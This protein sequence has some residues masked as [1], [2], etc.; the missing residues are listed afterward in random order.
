MNIAERL[1]GKKKREVESSRTESRES[2]QP[3][4]RN[5]AGPPAADE[6][7][8][9]S[10]RSIEEKRPA[11]IGKENWHLTVSKDRLTAFLDYVP[12]SDHPSP[13]AAELIRAAMELGVPEEGIFSEEKLET[14]LRNAETSGIPLRGYAICEDLEGGF[15]INVSEDKLR[16]TLSL[17]K[18]RGRGASLDLKEVGKALRS[19]NIKRLD[20]DKLKADILEFYRGPELTLEEYELATGKAPQSGGDQ[21]LTWEIEFM[22]ATDL[23]ELK[24]SFAEA[25]AEAFEGIASLEEC[26]IEAVQDATFI[27]GEM[28][29]ATLSDP[30]SAEN[31]IDVYGETIP[32]SKGSK[33]P[34]ELHENCVK[35]DTKIA[36]EADGIL[37][38]WV[39]DDTPHIRVRPHADPKITVYISENAMSAS[40]DLVEGVGTGKRLHPEEV[41]QALIDAGVVRGIDLEAVEEAITTAN[42]EG[43]A[44]Q[45]VVARGEQ[46]QANDEESLKFH[47]ELASGKGVTI[48]E[49]GRADFKNQ[50]RFTKVDE[51]TL[52]AEVVTTGTTLRPG[53]DVKGNTIEAKEAREFSLDIGENIK[54]ERDE[55]GQLRLIAGVSGE[56]AY[57]GKSIDIVGVHL[58]KGDVGP[59]TGNI[60]FSGPVHIAGNVLPGFFVIASGDIKVAAG[61]EAALLS[62]EKSIHVGQGIIG[63]GKAAVRAREDISAAFAERVVLMAVRDIRLK[64]ACLQSTVKCNGKLS[65]EGEKGH[66]VGGEVKSRHGIDM[67]NLG[68]KNGTRTLVSFGQDYLIGDKIE[69]EE[70]ELE[71][72]KNGA[73]QIDLKIHQA[74]KDGDTAELKI[75]R[76]KKLQVLKLIE[77]RTERLFWLREKF[78][79]HF[80][81]EVAVRGTAYPG[82][83]LESHNRTY[84]VTSEM[85]KVVFFFNREKGIIENR[86][87]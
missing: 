62:S 80:E 49:N 76:T 4:K 69:L 58:V 27:R 54:Q 24:K 85:Q 37:E 59:T 34:L 79:Q 35:K 82:A 56:L 44:K 1:L 72:L 6:K 36:S 83:V 5:G 28:L 42:E 66:L 68:A 18:G 21:E 29:I 60:R 22:P 71:K 55:Q 81:A 73:V 61:V 31:G 43:A 67:V 50:D 7:P 8:E 40:V 84:E 45:V 15:E 39:V 53:F 70:K 47:I 75:Q 63:G 25:P 41:R 38:R 57:D 2:R 17:A 14:A 33:I 13:P 51:G 64:N 26:P 11:A 16:A 86:P 30:E 65:L 52:I 19:S 87:L 23:A 20:F 78:E 10:E 74:E 12:K 9:K 46:P 32:A 48:R 3:A 77:R